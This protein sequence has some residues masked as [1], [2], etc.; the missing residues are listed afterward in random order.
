LLKCLHQKLKE[1]FPGYMFDSGYTDHCI[2]SA[3][4][5]LPDQKEDLLGTY[6]K[7]LESQGKAAIA[8]KLVPGVRFC[9]SD[10]GL[11]S[12]KVSALLLGMPCPIHIGGML[13]VD[14]RRQSKVEDFADSL[15]G[16]FA[17]FCNA[18]SLLEKL[19]STYLNY[20][21]NAM[22]A[23]CKKLTM[24]KKAAMEAV[25]MFEGSIGSDAVTAHDVFMALQEII[26]I[27]RTS[28]DVSDSKLLMTE[29]NLSRA[30]TLRWKDYDLAK[31]VGW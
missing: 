21:V 26:F 13:S 3:S 27:L 2:T 9:T 7:I 12:A 31:A 4:W 22:T 1:R 25:A 20:P 28:E 29:E 17:Q 30:L 18:I 16:M 8:G 24:P 14:H 10:T 15:D 5:S 23:I 11:A 19:A 6:K